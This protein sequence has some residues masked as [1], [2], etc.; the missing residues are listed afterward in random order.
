[1]NMA[2]SALNF[3][4]RWLHILLPVMFTSL[5][6]AVG[7][8]G[9]GLAKT[10]IADGSTSAGSSAAAVPGIGK[11]AVGAVGKG[12]KAVRGAFKK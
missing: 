2:V 5:M 1:M 11:N 4:T 6:G 7:I 9:A 12:A 8:Q 10:A 3:I